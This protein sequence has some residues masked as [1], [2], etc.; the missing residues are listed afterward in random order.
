M[1]RLPSMARE[2]GHASRRGASRKTTNASGLYQLTTSNLAE[3]DH[4]L[5]A[6]ATHT[7]RNQQSA[8]LAL[9][10]DY[11]APTISNV[12]LSTST[13]HQTT[14][15]GSVDID[16]TQVDIV[17]KHG[18]QIVETLHATLDGKGGYSVDATNLPD[19][20]YTA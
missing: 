5:T 8:A 12:Y 10:V 11:T 3:G 18:N 20:T 13:T 15:A 17:I 7:A 4:T 6:E 1:L 16:T 14:F 19:L 9:Q 2:S